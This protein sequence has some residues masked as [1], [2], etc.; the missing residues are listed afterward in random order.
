M[1]GAANLRQQ[2]KLLVPA[3]EIVAS[4]SRSQELE[5]RSGRDEG[6]RPEGVAAT[7]GAALEVRQP[8]GIARF[9]WGR[10]HD[11]RCCATIPH[12]QVVSVA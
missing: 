5:R 2:Q 9:A 6:G 8:K 3:A 11:S 4:S 7:M 12:C 10:P 1:V